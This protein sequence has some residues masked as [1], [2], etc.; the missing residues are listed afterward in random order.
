MFT[1]TLPS[2]SRKATYV[3]TLE[4]TSADDG[5]LIDLTGAAITVSLAEPDD[6]A[7]AT[8]TVDGGGVTIVS[9]G[10]IQWRFEQPVMSRAD[11]ESYQLSVVISRDG[12]STEILNASLP[13]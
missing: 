6:D 11:V 10:V 3:E 8:A 12:D 13:V 1:E 2:L 7:F 5:S 9:P 4:L